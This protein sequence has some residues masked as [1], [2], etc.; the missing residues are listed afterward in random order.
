MI[1]PVKIVSSIHHTGE[2]SIEKKGKKELQ[3]T[4]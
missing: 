3:R 1:Q 2:G 4:V